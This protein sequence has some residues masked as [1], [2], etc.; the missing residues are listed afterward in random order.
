MLADVIIG[1]GVPLAWQADG[2]ADLAGG[3]RA[4]LE[5][6]VLEESRMYRVEH[7]SP[8]QPLDGDDLLPGVHDP[9]GSGRS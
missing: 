6:V 2:G 9:Q 5:G 4:A 7:V 8:A 3:A 1:L